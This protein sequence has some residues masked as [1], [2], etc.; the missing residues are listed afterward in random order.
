MRMNCNLF[1]AL[2]YGYLRS[3]ARYCNAWGWKYF[4]GDTF[5]TWWRVKATECD[6]CG[7]AMHEDR[8]GRVH[9]G[10]PF[11]CK[12]NVRP[13]APADTQTPTTQ[14]NV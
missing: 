3:M 10:C 9:Y 11:G 7:H 12:A 13:L 2:R 8:L 4:W 6:Q 5:V 14:E 1:R